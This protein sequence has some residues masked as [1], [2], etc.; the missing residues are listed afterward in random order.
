MK[1]DVPGGQA[2]PSVLFVLSSLEGGGAEHQGLMMLDGLTAQEM[3]C[4]LALLD[5]RGPLLDCVESSHWV[6]D[7]GKRHQYDLPFATWGLRRLILRHRPDVVM[8]F[9]PLANTAAA[10]AAV[11]LPVRLIMNEMTNPRLYVQSTRGG[12]MWR[13]VLPAV[14]R[15]AHCLIANSSLA[16]QYLT[17]CFAVDQARVR[18]QHNPVDCADIARRAQEAISHPWFAPAQWPVILGIGRLAP[19]KAFSVLLESFAIVRKQIPAR[20]V[21]LGD[22]PERPRLEGQ[23]AELEL[24]GCVELPGFVRNPFPYLARSALLAIPSLFEG[25]PNV[26]LEAMACGTPVV[27]FK[28]VGGL[29]EIAEGG[30]AAILVERYD[31]RALATELIRVLTDRLCRQNLIAAANIRAQQHDVAKV[32][33]EYGRIVKETVAEVDPCR[34]PERH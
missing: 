15:R 3:H 30:Q 12:W 2:H 31:P 20:L 13:L 5:R 22:G 33:G 17:T 29:D 25:L 26:A 4:E 7:L 28:G 14:Y 8:S 10:I 21:V 27:G 16:A 18:V 9:L 19:E 1:V 6:Y 34:R 11:G 23:V 24:T 32:M